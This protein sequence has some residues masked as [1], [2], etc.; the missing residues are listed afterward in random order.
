MLNIKKILLPVDFPNPS[1]RVVH[2][3]AALAHHFHSEIVMLHVVTARSHAAGVP[4][5]GPELAA[6]D[7]LAEMV[8][9]A[10]NSLD[11]SLGP[12]LEGLA[13]RC[14]LLKGDPA[15]AIVQTTQVEKA[16]MIMMPSHG[17]TFNQFLLGSVTAKVLHG[18]ECPVWT[19]AHVEESTVQEFAIRNVL[20][21]VDLGPR[22]H[23]TVSW[24]AQMA[25]EFGACLTLV[26]VTA[27]AEIWAPGGSYVNPKWK[28]QLVGDASQHLAEL[29]QDMGIKADV[30]IGSGDVPKV[31]SQ[32]AKQTKADLLVSGC[33][34]YGG[35]LRIHGYAIIC[36]VP[37]PVLSV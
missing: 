26:H 13:I 17:Y 20:C 9:G 15:R 3:A 27:S 14:V 11:Q 16:D 18:T 2:Q 31:L 8:K 34:P 29:Q 24:A 1:L 25:A 36:A 37:I 4:E 5:D 7:M 10:Q 28:E 19:S 21:V 35:N 22:S 32:A 30:L 12:E 33:Y 6:W 23:Q